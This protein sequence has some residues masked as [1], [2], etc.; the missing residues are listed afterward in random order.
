L[1]LG[2]FVAAASSAA[3]LAACSSDD[4]PSSSSGSTSGGSSSGKPVGDAGGLLPSTDGSVGPG[5]KECADDNKLVY[6]ISEER[7]L[8]RFKPDTLVFTPV[9]IVRCDASGATPTSMAVDRSGTAWVR[10]SDGRIWKVSTETA[11]CTATKYESGQEGFS[12]FGMGFSVD[13]QSGSKETLFLSETLGKGLASLDV[14]SLTVKYIGPP[15]APF[16]G[17][18]AELTGT[19]DGHLYGF[20]TTSPAQIAELDKTTGKAMNPVELKNTFVGVAWA[21]SFYGGDFYVYTA[22]GGGGLPRA[23]TGSKITR[24]RPSDKSVT[25]LKEGVGFTIV[26]AGVSTCAPLVG[27]K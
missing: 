23:Q 4:A 8:Y 22:A 26:G 25:V 1:L 5:P 7:T 18:G 24:Y 6:V 12:K 10:H 3:L 16:V 14:S 11:A 15:G 13:G 17:T 2:G 20:F 21:F 27:P 9:G 19:G